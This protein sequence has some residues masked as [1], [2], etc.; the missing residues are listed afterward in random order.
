[1][2]GAKIYCASARSNLQSLLKQY[3]ILKAKKYVVDIDEAVPLQQELARLQVVHSFLIKDYEIIRGLAHKIGEAADEWQ[4]II[5]DAKNEAVE[6]DAQKQFD[7]FKEQ[8]S[9]DT[10]QMESCDELLLTLSRLACICVK[11]SESLSTKLEEL[12]KKTSGNSG[13]NDFGD[14]AGSKGGKANDTGH[15]S[16]GQRLHNFYFDAANKDRTDHDSSSGNRRQSSRNEDDAEDVGPQFDP[17][18]GCRFYRGIEVKDPRPAADTDKSAH[19]APLQL[20]NL[21]CPKFDGKITE[22]HTFRDRFLKFVD[23]PSRNMQEADKMHFLLSQLTGKPLDR[24]SGFPISTKSYYQIL[25]MLADEYD[26]PEEVM[27]VLMHRLRSLKPPE[28]NRHALNE[29]HCEATRIIRQL[30]EMGIETN[31]YE[32][33]RTIQ[34]RL[35]RGTLSELLQREHEYRPWNTDAI[36]A[37]LHDKVQL[38]RKIVRIMNPDALDPDR[39]PANA[40]RYLADAYEDAFHNEK[41]TAAFMV[42]SGTAHSAGALSPCAFCGNPKHSTAHCYNYSTREARLQRCVFEGIC[43]HCCSREPRPHLSTSCPNEDQGCFTCKK[44]G[45]HQALCRVWLK[46]FAGRLERLWPQN[47]IR[48]NPTRGRRSPPPRVYAAT[49][50]AAPTGDSDAESDTAFDKPPLTEQEEDALNAALHED[51]QKSDNSSTARVGYSVLANQANGSTHTKLLECTKAEVFNRKNGLSE[52]VIVFFDSGSDTTYVERDLADR[53]QLPVKAHDILDVDTFA[54]NG[55]KRKVPVTLRSLGIRLA[56]GNDIKLKVTAGTGLIGNI[57]S[58]LISD[59]DVPLLR[60]N[61]CAIIASTERPLVLIGRDQQ[62]YFQKRDDEGVLP[63]GFCLVRTLLGPILA[64]KGHVK[65]VNW[66]SEVATTYRVVVDVPTSDEKLAHTDENY[67][68]TE[69]IGISLPESET[70][71]ELVFRRHRERLTRDEEG[72]YVTPIPWRTPG[73]RP[74]T[75]DEL[76]PNYGLALGRLNTVLQNQPQEVLAQIDDSFKSQEAS[77]VIEKVDPRERSAYTKHYLASQ[78]VVKETSNTTKLRI[79]YDASAGS[80]KH[81][82]SLNDCTHRGPVLIPNLPGMLLRARMSAIVLT[83]DLEKAYLQLALPPEDRDVCRFLWLKDFTKPLTDDN[84]IVY[85]SRRVT[86]GLKPAPFMLAGTLYHHLDGIGSELAAEIKRN[87]YVDNIV[88]AANTVEQALEKYR[89]TKAIFNDAKMN[90]R[91]FASNSNEVM[92]Q[93][94]KEDVSSSTALFHSLGV[95]WDFSDD[96]WVMQLNRSS[97]RKP[98]TAAAQ[99]ASREGKLTRRQ[100]SSRLQ[101]IFDPMGLISPALIAAKLAIQLTYLL[102]LKWDDPVPDY[103]RELW[104]AATEGWDTVTI[105]IPRRVAPFTIRDPEIHIFV[106]ASKDAYGIAT[107]LRCR[108]PSSSEYNSTLVFSRAKVKPA[109]ESEKLTIPD[110]ELMAMALGAR[111]AQYIVDNLGMAHSAS[112]L[113]SDSMI[114]LQRVVTPWKQKQLWVENRLKEIRE[115]QETLGI[116]FRHVRTDQNPAD[117]VSRGIPANELQDNHLW[118]HGAPFLRQPDIEWPP[119]PQVLPLDDQSQATAPAQESGTSTTTSCSTTVLAAHTTPQRPPKRATTARST[120]IEPLVNIERTNDYQKLLR[121][122]ARVLKAAA[123]FWRAGTRSALWQRNGRTQRAFGFDLSTCFRGSAVDAENI[124]SAETVMLRNA[125]QRDPPTDDTIRSLGLVLVQGIYRLKGRLQHAFHHAAAWPIYV[126]R[127]ARETRLLIADYHQRHHHAG[128]Q[129]T[130]ANIRHR[131]WFTQGLRTVRS[132][133]AEYCWPCRRFDAKPFPTPRWPPLPA[134]R[135]QSGRP[136][137]AIGVDFFGP[138]HLKLTNSDGST[139]VRKHWVVIFVCMIVRAIHMEIVDSM[140]TTSFIRALNRFAGRRGLP[141]HILSDNG[142]QLL[143][144]RDVLQT[145]QPAVDGTTAH[146]AEP[147]KTLEQFLQEHR[148]RWTTITEVAP[149]RG[150]SYERLIGPVKN[151]LRRSIGSGKHVLTR[152]DFET[153]LLGAE[154]TVN[155]R[156]LTYVSD[157]THEFRIIRPKDFLTPMS[158]DERPMDA[159]L[160]PRA[161]SGDD[162]DYYPGGT[163]STRDRVLAILQQSD[164]KLQR[165]WRIWRDDYLAS[166]RERGYAARPRRNGSTHRHPQLGDIVLVFDDTVPR[167]CWKLARIIGLVKDS[168]DQV[169]TARIL[170]ANR[171]EAHRAI[172]HLYPLELPAQDVD[173]PTQQST[174]LH[175]SR[176]PPGGFGPLI[177]LE[178]EAPEDPEAEVAEAHAQDETYAPIATRTRR[179]VATTKLAHWPDVLFNPGTTVTRKSRDAL[180]KVSSIGRV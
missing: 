114:N 145:F 10:I 87:C 118:W 178:E 83:T 29:F 88:L 79:V 37:C 49:S 27:A 6:D 124:D 159:L 95:D 86:F 52:Q 134:Y 33:M 131:V 20:H 119:Q 150:G 43:G 149:W 21:P 102:Q 139:Y 123:V 35:P 7:A 108:D 82:S 2:T 177:G 69:N 120:P 174:S 176:S 71:D 161:E 64:G 121:V 61:K 125:Q 5:R 85:R 32:I 115:F 63:S 116:R 127:T 40:D 107:Y 22:F 129:T 80:G 175:R 151:C 148:I 126:P 99:R 67:W 78:V 144:A 97:A 94:P 1:M 66:A 12:D 46:Q 117:I 111:N 60:Q 48:K 93:L 154:S 140:D 179:R 136:F 166:L 96:S 165:F 141:A 59:K 44:P 13:S 142:K 122:H 146:S 133:V 28:E 8:H 173:D 160:P 72:R 24:C 26:H 147:S 47:N 11:N 34:S 128:A 56:N 9:W 77:G 74:V 113:W 172:N 70:D 103:I 57:R 153:L 23:D 109:S 16:R 58:A 100:M 75:N 81:T 53:L 18:R 38:E 55:V 157:A 76:K 50:G 167:S 143:A 84:L 19:P 68:K 54:S 101:A 92:A 15:S 106:D 4:T 132:V 155:S 130:L 3:T 73:G 90:A 89:H 169:P 14:S 135:V 91:E 163:T 41:G 62:H 168:A 152:D 39:K 180:V 110:L 164:D 105:R 17:R 51:L 162:V 42:R 45:H 171:Y 137:S 98:K 156:P 30:E 158:A 170:F 65:H 36:L 104:T 25:D 112:Y 138:I 31:T